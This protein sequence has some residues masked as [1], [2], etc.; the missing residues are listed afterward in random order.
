MAIWSFAHQWFFPDLL[1]TTWSLRAWAYALSDT[2]GV[3]D[4]LGVT[5]LIAVCTTMLSLIVGIP[6]GRAIGLFAF[7]GKTWIELLL[8][9]PVVVPGIA[10]VFGIHSIFIAMGLNNTVTGVIL[11]H[12]IPTLPYTVLVVAGV[13]ANYDIS[14]EHQARTLGATPW[15]VVWHVMLP[16]ILPGVIVGALFAFLVSWSQYLL[17]LMIGGGKVVTLPLL[18][19]NFAS[20]GRNDVTGA[21]SLLYLMPGVIIIL[22]TSR[23]LSDTEAWPKPHG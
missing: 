15:Q 2:A 12:L 5:L 23:L 22:L 17:T 9:A 16:T 18:L 20:A 3:L 1:P 4:S 7:R 21:L 10:V 6:A 14:I 11:V 19:F 8:L 13:F